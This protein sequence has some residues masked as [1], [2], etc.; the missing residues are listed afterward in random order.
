MVENMLNT[1]IVTLPSDSG[2]EFISTKFSQ[3]LKY[4][5]ISHQLSCP[6]TPEQNGCAERK[7]RHLV[8]TAR[9]LLATSKVPHEY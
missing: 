6:H 7:H 4:H 3:F 8:E 9:T 5:G 1:K 2:G